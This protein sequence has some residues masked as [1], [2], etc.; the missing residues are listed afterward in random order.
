MNRNKEKT[1]DT[2]KDTKMK[3]N[4]WDYI[5]RKTGKMMVLCLGVLF[6]EFLLGKN[7]NYGFSIIIYSIA[8]VMLSILSWF[9]K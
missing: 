5:L 7:D 4:F 1:M 3:T 2:T 9:C 8:S 6:V